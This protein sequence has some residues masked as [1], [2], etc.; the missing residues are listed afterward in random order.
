[1]NT[2]HAFNAFSA[3]SSREIGK[4]L[5]QKGRLFSAL[6][7][8]A[9]WLLVFAAGFQNVFGVAVIPPY[10][11]YIEYEVYIT[12]GL[13]CMVI[14]FNGMQSSL[15]MVYDR[16]VGV[17][18]LLLTAPLPRWY[19]LFCKLMA[20]TLLSLLQVYAF[21]VICWL[22][23][24]DLPV[25][26]LLSA[27]PAFIISAL[28]LGALGLLLSVSVKQLENFAGMMNFVIFPM[29]FMS[30]ALYPLWKLEEAGAE[31]VYQIAQFNP[32]TH[33]VELVR[34][35]LYGQLNSESLFVV[36]GFFVVFFILAVRG[37]DPQRGSMSQKGRKGG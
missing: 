14:L 11:S 35:A 24:V 18:R 26:G 16:E 6:V 20:G 2:V 8:P 7:R 23:D 37:Y 9:L 15:T 3:L 5:R 31:L 36:A 34:F 33:A 1:M 27:L 25:Y 4:F 10:E 28:M 12:P 32:F 17:M 13:L 19:I 30:P 29:F 21:L 22:F